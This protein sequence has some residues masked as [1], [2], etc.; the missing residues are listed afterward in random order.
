MT[1]LTDWQDV[2]GAAWEALV[3]RALHHGAHPG[4]S[5]AARQRT[6][7]LLFFN[8]SLRTRTSMEVA[9]AQLGAHTTVLT[10]GGGTWNLEW[11]P[12]VAMDGDAAE[13]V[14]EAVGV[15]SQYVD[16]LGV[17]VFASGTDYR[18]DKEEL[19][20]RAIQEA[21]SVPVINLESAFYHPCQ[22]LADAAVLRERHGG[23][24]E[25]R[26]FVL[27]WA[28][29]LKPLP[30]AVPNSALL[31]AAREGFD[32]TVARPEGYALDPDVMA[33]ARGYGASVV[34]TDDLEAACDGAH[35]VY[36]KAWGGPLAYADP[37]RERDLRTR[38]HRDWRIGERHM[39]ATAS[40]AFMHCL[41]VRRGVVVDGAVL[42]GPQA[43]H[44]RQAAFRLFAAKAVLEWVWGVG[45][46]LGSR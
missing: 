21:A 22:A 20:L 34:E 2:D 6:L 46:F 28:T 35:V 44:I 30:M 5:D 23:P 33:T 3:A 18:Q 19:A 14:R 31:M 13:H 29:H 37:E 24:G 45:G 39:A 4:W 9:A 38:E 26:R 12:D 11:R 10:P 7:G 32:V 1:H 27:A 40:G 25:R 17:R 36:A 8:P 15:L 41:P 43:I 42:D 16:A